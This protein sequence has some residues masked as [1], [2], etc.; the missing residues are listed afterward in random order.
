MADRLY[1][2]TYGCRTNV[3]DSSRLAASLVQQGFSLVNTPADADIVVVNSCTVTAGADRDAGKA[4]RRARRAAPGALLVIAGC[5]PAAY[6]GHDV[7]QYADSVVAG[8]DPADIARAILGQTAVHRPGILE[9]VPQFPLER[10]KNLSRANVK[11]MEGCGGHCSYCIVPVARG[12]PASRDI[13]SVIAEIESAVA[14]G[15]TEVVL[16]GTNIA[17]YGV[18]RDGRDD[19]PRLLSEIDR[20]APPCRVRLS[21]LEPDDRLFKVIDHM[22]GSQRWC[23]HIHLAVQHGADDLLAAMGRRYDFA[24]VRRFVEYA[25]GAIE[26]L[27]LGLDV[28]VGFPSET[29]AL[30]EESFEHLSSLPFTYL[31]VFIFSPRPGTRAC[32]LDGAPPVQEAKRRSEKLRNLSAER[33]ETFGRSFLGERVHVLVENRRDR[34]T[35]LLLGLTDNYLRVALI[36][37]DAL[38]GRLVD[39]TLDEG[40]DGRLIARIEDKEDV[41]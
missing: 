34:L 31:H 24:A 29:R 17:A 10:L 2:D 30:F 8:N 39:C 27:S 18:D 22:A 25:A 36:G 3:A 40:P 28:I 20:F 9:P 12:A 15:F 33:R 13:A 19:L 41:A 32:A 11:I 23:R 7:L 1:I 35:G 21:S 37:P 16:T 14:A 26:G 6:D 5:I 38:Q 4:L